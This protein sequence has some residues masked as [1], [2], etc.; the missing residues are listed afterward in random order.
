MSAQWLK[1]PAFCVLPF[2]EQH[3]SLRDYQ[4]F[5]CYG[6]AID[7]SQP[8]IIADLK[9]KILNGQ[10]IAHCQHCYNLENNKVISPRLLESSRWLKDPEVKDYIGSWSNSGIQKTFFYDIRYDNK[11]NLACISCGPE[12]SSLWAKEMQLPSIKREV[13]L[14][15]DQISKAKKVYLAGGEP[16]INDQVL[17]LIQHIADSDQQPELVINTNLTR[18]NHHLKGCLNK[19]KNLTVVVSVDA[20]EKVNEYHRWPMSWQKFLKNLEWL[21]EIRCTIQFNTVVDAVSVLNLHRLQEIEHLCD[22]WN[23]SIATKPLALCVNNLPELL[24]QQVHD[25]FVN[26]KNSKFYKNDPVFKTNA[27]FVIQNILDPGD[28]ILLSSFIKDLDR[29]RNIN[30]TTYLET[31]LT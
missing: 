29:R 26:I 13:I 22:Q 5:C 6:Q 20:W 8:G 31:N 11:C 27:D 23:L 30:H 21:L 15:I 24:K 25:N 12:E 3:F 14:D 7:S 4:S 18:I 16:L 10:K 19:I 9:N 28:P 17:A 1:N 2:I